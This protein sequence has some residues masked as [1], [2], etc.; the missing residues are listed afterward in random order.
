M[1]LLALVW[2]VSLHQALDDRDEVRESGCLHARSLSGVIQESHGDDL[3]EM[4]MSGKSFDFVC[5]HWPALE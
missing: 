4:R 5:L 2:P 3:I 1:R